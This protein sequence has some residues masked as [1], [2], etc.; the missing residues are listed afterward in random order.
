MSYNKFSGILL[1]A[2]FLASGC[3]KVG[4]DFVKPEADSMPRWLEASGYK[5]VTT[6]ADDYRDWWRSFNDPVLDKLIGNAYQQN[7]TLRI[8]GVR[9]LA[10]RAQ[11]GIAVGELYPQSQQ[12]KGSLQKE[13]LSETSPLVAPGSPVNF[14]ASQVGVSANWEID[15]WGKF[16][17]AVESAD[18]SLMAAVADYD[19]ALVSLTGDVANTYISLRTLEKRLVIAR[20]NVEIQKRSLQIATARWKGGTTSKRDVE[21]AQTVLDGTEA[22]IPTLEAQ[23]RQAQN[24]LSVLMGMPPT[25]L[26]EFLG[27][28]SEIPSPPLQVAVGIPADLLRRRPDIRSAE[29]RAAAQSAQIGVAKAN[30]YPAF[31][32]SGTFGLQA[33]D[34]P[35]FVLSN[36][37][38][39]RSRTGTFG[40]AFQWNLFNYGQITNQVRFQDA[41]LQELLITYQNTVLQAQQEVENALIGFLKAQQRAQKLV[42]ATNAAQRSVDLATLQYRQGI[43]DFTTVLTAEQNLLIYQDS[44]ASTLGDI[45]SNLVA[46]YRAMGGGWQLRE[47]QDVVPDSVK[48][49]MAKRTNWGKL[50]TPVA[51]PPAPEQAKSDIRLPQW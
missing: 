49:A 43:T 35:P 20:Q 21:Q 1:V 27:K 4:P 34:V 25:D 47:G 38:D 37:F 5:Q 30:L 45:S 12:A 48:E 26:K 31:S 17:R 44:L 36:M 39:W 8:A 18:A 50:L 46:M 24:A 22:S 11:L 41:R 19:N 29:Y 32:L 15:F 7:L 6:K 3:V 40:P 13:R 10:A 33:A 28:K 14:W 23:W 51:L 9:V 16:R 42:G 2:L